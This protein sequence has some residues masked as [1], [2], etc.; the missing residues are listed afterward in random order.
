MLKD[1]GRAGLIASMTMVLCG[2]VFPVIL[3]AFGQLLFEDR[4]QGSIV[5][6]SEEPIGSELIAQPFVS[7]NYFHGR[8]SAVD[9]LTGQSGGDNLAESHPDRVAYDP[10][11]PGA[12]ETSASG[13]DPHISVK[14]ALNQVNRI[15]T[16]RQL[17][18]GAVKE[19]IHDVS[20]DESFV[21]VLLLNLRL[22]ETAE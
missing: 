20:K 2:V 14:H 6:R 11:S 7:D 15:A 9:Q 3:L 19:L 16:A 4:A 12:T 1:W 21:N 17:E 5:E 18:P 8:P 10:S 13:L 22:D